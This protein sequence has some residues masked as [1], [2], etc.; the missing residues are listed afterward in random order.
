MVRNLKAVARPKTFDEFQGQSDVIHRLRIAVSAAKQQKRA[1]PHTLLYG[2]PG[3]GKT[4]LAQIIAMERGV[5]YHEFIAT[6]VECAEDIMRYLHKKAK[7]NDIIFLDEIHALDRRAMEGMYRFMEDAEHRPIKYHDKV[8]EQVPLFDKHG[9]RVGSKPKL[10]KRLIEAI[11]PDITIIGATTNVGRLTR[12]FRD[13]FGMALTLHPY[14]LDTLTDIVHK[15]CLAAEIYIDPNAARMVARRSRRTVRIAYNIL[16]SCYD[17]L[18]AGGWKLR[19]VPEVVDMMMRIEGVDRHGL[20]ELDRQYLSILSLSSTP[21]GAGT[22]AS[23]L[24]F[25]DEEVISQEI[26]PFLLMSGM[27]QRT[28]RGRVITDCGRLVVAK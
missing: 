28:P 23:S 4:T 26:E 2:G 21:V 11:G 15:I 17:W 12:P 1:V 13:R 3:L 5:Q 27:I 10:T 20:R 19:I 25:E 18:V 14:D 24:G 9:R 6:Q 16:N 7:D 8:E 22:L